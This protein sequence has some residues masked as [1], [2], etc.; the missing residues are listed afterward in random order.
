M[1]Q[2]L[3]SQV[4]DLHAQP[5]AATASASLMRLASAIRMVSPMSS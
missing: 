5:T 1:M 2:L 4:G 3:L